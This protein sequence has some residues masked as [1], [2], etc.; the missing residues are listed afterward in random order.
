LVIGSGLL[1]GEWAER[2]IALTSKL[3]RSPVVARMADRTA[4]VVKLTLTLT[5]MGHNLAKTGTPLKRAHYEAK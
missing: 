5:L 2:Q 1:Q 3:T 4:A